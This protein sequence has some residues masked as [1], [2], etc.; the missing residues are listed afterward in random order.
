MLSNDAHTDRGQLLTDLVL[1]VFRLNG[2][3]GEVGDRLA[4][5]SAQ[6]AS[7]W[8]VLGCIDDEPRSV[9]EIAKLM[10]LTRQSVQRTANI[11]VDEG[12]A[13]YQVN[14]RHVRAKLVEITPRGATALAEIERRQVAWANQFAE[15]LDKSLLIDARETLSQ[16]E[17]LLRNT[18]R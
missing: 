6:T 13:N 10:G 18:D 9:A 8:Q 14:P 7:R 12:F 1:A 16:L 5:P 2:L 3:L 4:A 17:E 15:S 11:L